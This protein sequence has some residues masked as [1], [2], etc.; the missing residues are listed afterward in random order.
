[1]SQPR[2]GIVVTGTEVLTGRIRD[3]NGPWLAQRLRELGVDLVHV[4]L[5]RDRPE[6]V[7]RQLEFMAAEQMD[8]IITTGGLGPTADDLTAQVVC[9]FME[10]E[11]YLDEGLLERIEAIVR[12]YAE[13]FGWDWEALQ[14]G[15]R[16]Q[17]MVPRDAEILGP[18]GTAP[19]L[20]VA[21]P[22]GRQMPTV[23]V[24]P[25]PPRELQAMWPELCESDGFRAVV[26]GAPVFEERMLRLF[27]VAEPEIAKTMRIFDERHGLEP[28]EVTTC[29]RNG[30]TEVLISFD[31]SESERTAAFVAVIEERHG[32]FIYSPEGDEVDELVAKELAGRMLA[33]AESCTGGLVAERL[34]ATPGASDY[35]TGGV[36]AYSNAAKERLLG[37]DAALL[38]EHGAVS[39]EV[40]KA[41]AHG[42][43]DRFGADLA[44]AV[45]GV[46]GPG[47]GSPEKPVG[48][49][50]FHAC[51]RDGSELPLH[52]VLP[53]GRGDVRDRAATVGLH[54]MLRLLRGET[55]Q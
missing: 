2:A 30:E 47:G 3:A 49:V 52:V 23:C 44:L 21:T 24:L 12:P 53:G 38:A 25:G 50:Y 31:P 55:V 37:V 1:M 15:A 4:T 29:L 34:T 33:L 6:D 11:T 43:L 9:E 28:L 18:A 39:A 41:M 5:C 20:V 42:A 46:A 14:H 54:L 19:G 35:L 7:R 22:A 36:V 16:K 40:A 45:T 32:A 8:L 10:R 27:G 26:R 13:R 51:E 17:A 48:T